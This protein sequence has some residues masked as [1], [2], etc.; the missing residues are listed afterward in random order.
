ML[1]LG[2]YVFLIGMDWLERHQ[3]ILN[4]FQKNFNCL[5]DKGERITV[6]G[7]PRKIYV[8][9]ISTLQMKKVVRK[10]CKVFV[11]H[12]INNKQIDQEN[13]LKLDDIPILQDFSDVF[14]KE[15]PKLPP[16]RDLD[17]TIELVSGVVPKSKALYQ[18][19][20]L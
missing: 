7:I 4:C 9:Q 12:I 6:T 19:N 3:V 18:M 8:R 2:A 11:V 1:L 20:I 15:I 13:K 14:P 17:Y 10:G 16:K 5:N